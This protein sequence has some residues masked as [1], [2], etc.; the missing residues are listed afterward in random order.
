MPFLISTT[1]QRAKGVRPS[2]RFW[3]PGCPFVH[4]CPTR[5]DK[6]YYWN[7]TIGTGPLGSRY[8][9]RCLMV[10]ANT[11]FVAIRQMTDNIRRFI[12]F[13]INEQHVICHT[14][15]SNLQMWTIIYIYVIYVHIYAHICAYILSHIV[16]VKPLPRV[17]NTFHVQ[18]VVSVTWRLHL[19]DI[20]VY[21]NLNHLFKTFPNFFIKIILFCALDI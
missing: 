21:R 1:M 17:L 15:D 14:Q 5:T 2:G 11:S 13:F 18:P 8:A 19:K 6:G 3:G 16:S 4:E 20:D 12:H 7:W 10:D 9:G